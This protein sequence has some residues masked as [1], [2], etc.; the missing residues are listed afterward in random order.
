MFRNVDNIEDT[1]NASFAFY[2]SKLIR[3]SQKQII[4][5]NFKILNT[6]NYILYNISASGSF[7]QFANFS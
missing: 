3:F 5:L 1:A 4:V 2:R 6:Q 7:L